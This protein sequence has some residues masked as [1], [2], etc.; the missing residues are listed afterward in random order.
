M[1]LASLFLL[2]D[3]RHWSWLSCQ[4]NTVIEDSHVIFHK[5]ERIKSAKWNWLHKIAPKTWY[6][7]ISQV[8]RRTTKLSF[9]NFSFCQLRSRTTNTSIK[10]PTF[11]IVGKLLSFFVEE[12]VFVVGN[13]EGGQLG[14][15]R[16]AWRLSPV[17]GGAWAWAGAWTMNRAVNFVGKIR[18]DL[19]RAEATAEAEADTEGPP[20]WPLS[21]TAYD[22][23]HISGTQKSFFPG[24]EHVNTLSEAVHYDQAGVKFAPMRRTKRRPQFWQKQKFFILTCT[25]GPNKGTMCFFEEL[26]HSLHPQRSSIEQ[27][28]ESLREKFVS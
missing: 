4:C 16:G 5:I 25:Q 3:E 9:K 22:A 26:Q 12:N 10:L 15:G 27:F 1:L 21:L 6:I 11:S 24:V 28:Y 23:S 17:T 19:E 8:L 18:L 20:A 13:T 7:Y 14:S 2:H